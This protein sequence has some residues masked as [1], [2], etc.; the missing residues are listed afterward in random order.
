M[1]SQRN[2]NFVFRDARWR[3]ESSPFFSLSFA[4]AR[5]AEEGITSHGRVDRC[6]SGRPDCL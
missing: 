6:F 4:Q 5:S 2:K 3:M 1:T